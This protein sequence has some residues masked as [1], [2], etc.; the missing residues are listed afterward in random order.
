MSWKVLFKITML[1]T[2]LSATVFSMYLLNTGHTKDFLNSLGFSGSGKTLHW[3]SDRLLKA[4]GLNKNWSLQE[5]DRQW[6]VRNENNQALVVDYLA[7]EKWLAQYC[8]LDIQPY[9][10]E[11]ILN[12]PLAPFLKILF[13]DNKQVLIYQK[14]M[15]VFQINEHTF[16]S[17]D[18][19]EGLLALQKLLGIH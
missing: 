19:R 3:C 12:T 15:Q 5:I 8:M 1:L 18:L 17:A 6:I 9:P 2:A 11:Q 16:E 7:V 10:R 13:K 14:D 4:E